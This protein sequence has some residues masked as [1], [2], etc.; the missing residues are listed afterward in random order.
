MDSQKGE[1]LL[2]LALDAT[3]G[4][5]ERS[6]ALRVGY[7]KSDRHW[8]LI[9]KYSGDLGQIREAFPDASFD[10]LAGG[11]AI[12]RIP[13]SQIEPLAGFSQIE[14]MEKP[15]RLY[16]SVN[17]GKEDACIARV[18][19]GE[20]GLSGR[21]V[22][23]AILDSG[24]DY[25]LD[26]FRD[27]DGRTRIL[28]LWDQDRDTVYPEEAI[29]AAL[30][31]G[32]REAA[33]ERV[34]FQDTSGHG[35]AV[36]ASAA[37]SGAPGD[38]RYRGVAWESRL[39]V[40]RL[41]SRESDF[42]P[43]T[44]Q[45]MRAADYAIRRAQ[46]LKM[47]VAV[48]ISLGHTYGS[49]DG[50]SLLET[51]LD[52]AA[53]AGRSSIVVGAGNE[54]D[55]PGHASGTLASGGE[56]VVELSL[57]EYEAGIGVQLWKSYADEIQVELVSPGGYPSEIIRP[58]PGTRRLYFPGT[59]VL[60]YYGMPSPY[61]RA[62][63]IYF[64]FLP[65]EGYVES[66]IWRFRLL[67]GR[68]ADGRYDLWLP[69]EA[70]RNRFTRFLAADPDTTLTIPSTASRVISAG[71]YD[72]AS[73]TYASFSGRGY[74]RFLHA[75]KPDLAAPGVGIVTAR[76]GGGYGPVTGTSFAAP[77]VTGSAALLME[78]GITRGNDPYLYGEKL[79]AYLMR[80]AARLPGEADYPNP[81][82]GYGTLC[83]SAAFPENRAFSQNR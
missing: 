79:K 49:H 46:E 25:W 27:A 11:Y 60:L 21:G 54:G 43:R 40:V 32:S 4:E 72:D 68:I 70:A 50:T 55:S 22:L 59:T 48:N 28:E 52:T 44:T 81:R 12:V 10:A 36:A 2:N 56:A 82:L 29:N 73:Q 19:G 35:T 66:G 30:A 13:E 23:V 63:E 64:D 51:Y 41:G 67:A 38:P 76:A 26:D 47:P 8:E 42:A 31:A 57:D 78:W 39:L 18:Q 71:A 7:D 75:V 74:T 69:P 14:Y 77:F 61:S 16:F 62:Q 20:A 1:N 17:K 33:Q 34:P 65:R 80:G 53:A 6:P 83:L 5:R 24:I 37:G 15:K 3:E 9:V 45:L 58:L